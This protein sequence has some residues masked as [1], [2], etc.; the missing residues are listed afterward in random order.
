[1]D[2]NRLFVAQK[3]I[4]RLIFDIKLRNTCKN[5]FRQF[6]I[7]T[8]SC[9]YLYKCVLYTFEHKQLFLTNADNHECLPCSRNL[10]CIPRHRTTL[11]EN[12]PYFSCA[13][14]YNR[15]P[16]SEMQLETKQA[17]KRKRRRHSLGKVLLYLGME[18]QF[19]V[20][21]VAR[22]FVSRM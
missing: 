2:M 13:A 6:E 10:I 11:D 4:I 5:R 7:M 20:G 19:L 8:L 15:L 14:T 3:R 16:L 9:I 17:F 18:Y 12:F 1:M 22:I 21:D